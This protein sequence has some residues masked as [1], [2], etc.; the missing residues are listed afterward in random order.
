MTDY[1]G[2]LQEERRP[3]L[4]LEKLKE[5]YFAL[6]R[7]AA[8]DAP[9]NEA[10]RVL[11]DPKLRLHHLLTLEDA[12]LTA[13]RPVP[14]SVADLFWNTG[15]VLREAERWLLQNPG[16]PAALLRSLQEAERAKLQGKI[17][18]L[19]DQLR[20]TYESQL[21][22]L[23]ELNITWRAASPND[24]QRL[25]ELYDSIAYLTRLLAQTGEK[26]FQ[27]AAG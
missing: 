15:A 17:N 14:P 13:G 26:K 1:F 22:L 3:W 7:V 8:P 6:S 19:N 9:L 12:D 18:R 10:Y 24:I 23:R 5:K 2:L 4:D 16:A 25:L 20:A 11:S 21:E 27:L